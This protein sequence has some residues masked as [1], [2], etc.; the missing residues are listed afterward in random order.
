M[1]PDDLYE[2][3]NLIRRQHGLTLEALLLLGWLLERMPPEHRPEA[4][5]RI[6][7]FTERAEAAV[8]LSREFR[9][10]VDS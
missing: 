5:A 8:E 2:M 9:E 1:T 3:W 6:A 4:S 7:G 10:R